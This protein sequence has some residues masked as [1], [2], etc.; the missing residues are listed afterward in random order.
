MAQ[1]SLLKHHPEDR[2]PV[3]ALML[4]LL[5]PMVLPLVPSRMLTSLVLPLVP[6]RVLHL[7]MVLHLLLVLHH[8][9]VLHLLLVLHVLLLLLLVHQTQYLNICKQ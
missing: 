2:H 5:L 3:R 9:L 7:M 4:L 8:L 6:C 1:L